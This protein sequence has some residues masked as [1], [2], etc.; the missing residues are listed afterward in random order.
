[1][2]P[3]L[4]ANLN[5]VS[6]S[7]SD[8]FNPVK[9]YSSIPGAGNDKYQI[10]HVIEF[11]KSLSAEAIR[12]ATSASV[13]GNWKGKSLIE[14]VFLKE[15]SPLPRWFV[16][17]TMTNI[18]STTRSYSN[19]AAVTV[20]YPTLYPE[21]TSD[22]YWKA[23]GFKFQK[24]SAE[25]PWEIVGTEETFKRNLKTLLKGFEKKET[26]EY[27][28]TG[29][30]ISRFAGGQNFTA[31][32]MILGYLFDY[33]VINMNDG[34]SP[35]SPSLIRSTIQ[36]NPNMSYAINASYV[37]SAGFHV[38]FSRT[39][40]W[41][42]R[43]AIYSNLNYTTKV[44][45]LLEWPRYFNKEK[46][47]KNPLYGVELEFA[48]GYSIQSLVDAQEDDLFAIFKQDSSV[49]GRGSV[50]T[51]LV[52]VPA[53]IQY[54]KRAFARW[55]HRL[56]VSQFDTTRKTNNGMH[57]HIGRSSFSS[58]Q[59]LR[60]FTWFISNPLNKAFLFEVSERRELS[61]FAQ[62]ATFPRFDGRSLVSSHI[63]T[64][65]A[66][67]RFEQPRHACVN[68]TN[69][70]TVEVRIF[71]GI[72]SYATVLKNLEFTDALLEF[73]RQTSF[74]HNS[75]SEFLSWLFKTNKGRYACFKA[76]AKTLDKKKLEEDDKFNRLV[77]GVSEPT[78][79]VSKVNG[80]GI[81]MTQDRVDNLNSVFGEEIFAIDD[82]DSTRLKII[83]TLGG[84]LAAR[85][86]EF[87]TRYIPRTAPP[88]PVIPPP[89]STRS[90]ISALD[91]AL[92]AYRTSWVV[93]DDIPD[94][95][96][97]DDLDHESEEV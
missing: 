21:E 73:T 58:G 20:Y 1:M 18:S 51:E 17:F 35:Q 36:Q 78:V 31:F 91:E 12:E 52:T 49:N 44:T 89:A 50:R 59:H 3:G 56:D 4:D 42:D 5:P 82:K 14:D 90:R 29:S 68:I 13:H 97:Y 10:G 6:L 74:S 81:P 19:V 76:F 96:E 47:A 38:T 66:L 65:A 11:Y 34:R 61:E 86:T 88:P 93:A 70:Q 24:N 43:A 80:K 55:F 22:Y 69:T 72:V 54:L 28:G 95:P 33:R 46:E 23:I 84:R 27:F 40:A 26:L 9:N 85:D 25:G 48:T 45:S 83:Y 75:I 60:N 37:A 41:A 57:I 53:S 94:F 64:D 8:F 79:L 39:I 16:P 87:S 71:K 30:M 2:F 62:Y 77:Y 32:E 67:L 7:L 92:S 15:G 63:G